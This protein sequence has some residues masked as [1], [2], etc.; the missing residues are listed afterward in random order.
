MISLCCR[1][2]SCYQCSPHVLSRSGLVINFRKGRNSV[3][4]TSKKKK[5][6]LRLFELLPPFGVLSPQL[7]PFPQAGLCGEAPPHQRHFL[8]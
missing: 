3:F 7:G 1:L 5:L 2:G 8:P 4:L 6:P